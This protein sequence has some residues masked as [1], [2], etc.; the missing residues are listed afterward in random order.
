[1]KINSSN[2]K[3]VVTGILFVIF[4]LLLLLSNFYLLSPRFEEIFLSWPMLLIAIGL[5]S[6][7]GRNY[8]AA[9]IIIF[10]GCFFLVPRIV[11]L[12]VKLKQ[13]W[14]IIIIFT[15]LV[16]LSQQWRAKNRNIGK[17]K[18][19]SDYID[20]F[21]ILS[22]KN[23]THQSQVFKGGRISSI[24]AGVNVDLRGVKLD[25][26]AT[27]LDI[28]SILGSVKLFVP[29]DWTVKNDL[30]NVL[31]GVLIKNKDTNPNSEE[32][33]LVIAGRVVMGNV[34]VVYV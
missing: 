21:I 6:L 33:I 1:M 31:G 3:R 7:A 13:L 5:V 28:T 9:S 24:L 19:F 23:Y 15:G 2:A 11:D 17:I 32:K 10:T 14:P 30:S 29:T 18:S 20:E 4:G 25:D 8:T 16:I 26:P 27:T 34:E 12:E 22:S